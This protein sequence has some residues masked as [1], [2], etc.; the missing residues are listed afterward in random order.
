MLEVAPTTPGEDLGTWRGDPGGRCIEHLDDPS[1]GISTTHPVETHDDDLSG[2]GIVDEDR[3][4]GRVTP[5][6]PT[7]DRSARRVHLDEI[8]PRMRELRSSHRRER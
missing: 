7:T 1:P 5:D 8:A 4:S 2:Q 6:S 3:P